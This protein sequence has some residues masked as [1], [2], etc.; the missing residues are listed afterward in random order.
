MGKV[1]IENKK[2]KNYKRLINFPTIFSCNVLSIN[3]RNLQL[4]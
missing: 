3:S 4:I 2:K 1:P